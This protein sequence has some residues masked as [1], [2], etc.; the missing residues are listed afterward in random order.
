VTSE[1]AEEGR[2]ERG[3]EQVLHGAI[4]PP[5]G[6]PRKAIDGAAGGHSAVAE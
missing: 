5:D 1:R 4:R 6:P 2:E 3:A